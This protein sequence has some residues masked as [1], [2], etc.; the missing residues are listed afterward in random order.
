M[1]IHFPSRLSQKARHWFYKIIESYGTFGKFIVPLSVLEETERVSRKS[2]QHELKYRQARS[3]IEAICMN[4]D[5]ALWNIFSFQSL[6]QNV[7]DCFQL[8][9][10][11]LY[12]PHVKNQKIPSLGDTLVLAHGI[13]NKCP[14]ASNEWFEKNDWAIVAQEFPFLELA[15]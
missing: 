5:R 13:Y 11:K 2:K 9:Y 4:P 8:L 15:D 14:V 3:V 7:F 1:N 12:S 6:T 10:E